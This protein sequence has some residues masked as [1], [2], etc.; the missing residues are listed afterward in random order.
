MSEVW[1][2]A[3]GELRKGTAVKSVGFLLVAM[4][5]SHNL[6]YL[7]LVRLTSSDVG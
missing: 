1:D 7:N 3:L 2:M 5:H 6:T 4:K